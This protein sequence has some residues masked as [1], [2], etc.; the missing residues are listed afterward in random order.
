MVKRK[1]PVWNVED[2]GACS[3]VVCSARLGR[4]VVWNGRCVKRGV[5]H[6]IQTLI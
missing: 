4:G 2:T 1:L 3:V 6:D 5:R